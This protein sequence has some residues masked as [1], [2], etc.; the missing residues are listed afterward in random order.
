VMLDRVDRKLIRR[1]ADGITYFQAAIQI[2]CEMG[3]F[4]SA[5]KL[6]KQ[7]AE[8]Y[9]K[10]NQLPEAIEAYNTASDYFLGEVMAAASTGQELVELIGVCISCRIPPVLQTSV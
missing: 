3:R 2:Y 4:S 5:A 10:S 9:E 7:I 6:Q 1:S 8:I